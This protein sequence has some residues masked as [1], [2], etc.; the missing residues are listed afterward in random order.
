MV[1]EDSSAGGNLA[2]PQ[3]V[4]QVISTYKQIMGDQKASANM[5]QVMGAGSDQVLMK[6]MQDLDDLKLQQQGDSRKQKEDS[7]KYLDDKSLYST[8]A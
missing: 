7:F 6:I 2:S 3:N 4:A 8:D 5:S 1:P